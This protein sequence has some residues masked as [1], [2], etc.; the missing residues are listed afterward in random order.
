M[1]KFEWLSICHVVSFGIDRGRGEVGATDNGGGAVTVVYEQPSPQQLL[2]SL[3]L[4]VSHFLMLYLFFLFAPFWF[5]ELCKGDRSLWERK[6]GNGAEEEE[7]RWNDNILQVCYRGRWLGWWRSLCSKERIVCCC[8]YYPQR[9][10]Q[11]NLCLGSINSYICSRTTIG[12]IAT[13]ICNAKDC[14]SFF[15]LTKYCFL[16]PSFSLDLKK[17]E[18]IQGN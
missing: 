14:C 1:I 7:L 17:C 3:F 8:R 11:V 18:F 12:I 16:V 15:P 5:N 9:Y 13:V 6:Q 4:W 2:L 10:C